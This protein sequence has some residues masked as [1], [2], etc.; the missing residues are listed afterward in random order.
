MNEKNIENFNKATLFILSYLYDC[1]PEKKSFHAY[2][3]VV[4]ELKQRYGTIYIKEGD[5]D[6][7]ADD[8]DL[9][10]LN[11]LSS[12]IIWLKEEGYIRF[13]AF[14]PID[15]FIDVILTSKALILLGK[16]SSLSKNEQLVDSIKKEFEKGASTGIQSLGK[17]LIKSGVSRYLINEDE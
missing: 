1:F 13:V 17:Q 2:S 14:K 3:L 12:T 8:G 9:E 11:C 5:E 10:F 6:P 15:E 4:K 7:T 16:P